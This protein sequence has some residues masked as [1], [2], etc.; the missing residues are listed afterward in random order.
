[1]LL[2]LIQHHSEH[3]KLNAEQVA[4]LSEWINLYAE[5]VKKGY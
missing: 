3:K 4:F 2:N 1:M 5:P